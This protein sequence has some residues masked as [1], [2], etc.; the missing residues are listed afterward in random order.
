MLH[1]KILAGVYTNC[2]Y[3]VDAER[4]VD[5]SELVGDGRADTDAYYTF[6][7]IY[8]GDT[9][10]KPYIPVH[11]PYLSLEH[12]KLDYPG[13]SFQTYEEVTKV[14]RQSKT[15]ASVISMARSKIGADQNR[16]EHAF[17]YAANAEEQVTA[18]FSRIHDA[19][20]AEEAV[21]QAKFNILAEV[22][23]AMLSQISRQPEQ[24]LS[25][26]R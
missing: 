25:L 2:T 8:A 9:E 19:D 12:L 26:L 24:V 13:D 14:M 21:N 22:Q 20:M 18:S 4:I 15:A 1:A 10:E 11:L 5:K 17:Q 23:R 3:D 7:M 16:L 6:V